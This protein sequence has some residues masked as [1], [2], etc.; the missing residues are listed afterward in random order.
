[1]S[2]CPLCGRVMC[3]HT[4]DE[5]EQTVEETRRNLTSEEEDVCLTGNEQA[6]LDLAKKN[7]HLIVVG[8]T[9]GRIPRE[10][11]LITICFI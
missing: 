1:M 5:R 10:I 8:K 11:D 6:K 4:P 9:P 7:A 2:L 3:D